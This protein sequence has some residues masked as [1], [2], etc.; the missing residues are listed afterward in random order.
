MRLQVAERDERAGRS[1]AGTGV[2]PMAAG[3]R[4]RRP[5]AT[6]ARHARA[7]GGR[8]RCGAVAV[9]SGDGLRGDVP[10]ARRAHD[11]R[12]PDAQPLDLRPARRH[13][14]GAGRGGR[15]A[16]EQRERDHGRRARRASSR[17]SRCSWRPTTSQQA[18][19]AAAVALAPD[20]LGRG[21]RARPQRG[22]R[23]RAHRRRRA[24]R[25][26][27]RPGALQA[28]RGGRL[29]RGR[30]ARLG[31]PARDAARGPRARSRAGA[32]GGSARADQ[33]ARRRGR[34]A[35]R[36][37]RSRGW[38][39]ATSSSSCATAASRP[40]G[41][42]WPPSSAPAPADRRGY[43]RRRDHDDAANAR[44][45]THAPVAARTR[46]TP[47]RSPSRR[48]ARVR[49]RRR[50]SAASEL[51]AAPVRWPRPVAPGG[52]AERCSRQADG[53]GHRRARAAT[54]SATCSSTCRATAARRA[55]SPR[56][57]RASRPPSRCRCARSPRAPVRRRGHA[58]A[59]RGDA[60]L[61]A[62]GT[63]ARRSSTSRGSSS[64]TR[65]ARGCCCT[66]RPT[67]AGG[68]RVSHHARPTAAP[69]ARRGGRA[70]AAIGRALP[71]R[72]GVSSTQILTLVQRRAAARSRDVAETLPAAHARG[73]APARPRRAR[74]RRCTS[75]ASPRDPR[76]GARRLAFEELLLTQLAVPAPP[77]AQRRARTG[78]RALAERAVAERALARAAGCRSRP[79]PTSA[80]RS[81]RSAT[82][83]RSRAPMQ[84]LLMGEVGSGKTVVALY[85]ML[86]AVEHGHQAALMAPT[87][88][89]AEQHF[90]TLQRLL[91]AEPVRVAL[92]TGSTPARRRAGHPRQA[93]ERRAVAD[94]RHARADRARR[95]ASAR[96]RWPWSTSS[97]A[98]ACASARRSRA[99]AGAPPHMLHM[100]ATPIPRTLAL[101]RY[102]DLDT[103][104]LRELPPGASRSRRAWSA[105]Q[106]AGASAYEQLREQLRARAPGVR[107]VPADRGG[108]E[109]AGAAS[110]PAGPAEQR[111]ARGDGRARAP[112]RGRAA[113]ATSSRCC[114]AACARA[115]SRRRWPR[116][117]PARP[118]CSSRRP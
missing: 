13:P 39:T 67:A 62:T 20:A 94:R 70:P 34:A 31:R 112:A 46:P 82:I 86:R 85:A 74:S 49:I 48:S 110:Q 103:S 60:C 8:V 63:C 19:L 42:C 118:T 109:A 9:V 29:R 91:G 107:R 58:P 32:D 105:R 89:L 104:T 80:R 22:A 55:R 61:D 93:R 50:P 45:E 15:R 44:D 2:G 54:P 88:T 5:S 98:S 78:A 69:S 18:G 99:P 24:G 72:E 41:G 53:R 43:D 76:P 56:C 38:S 4:P 106:R 66:A 115:R 84:R 65:P 52:P 117:P 25:A 27:R 16:A 6:P 36:S 26:R 81:T 95:R 59:G 64:A 75:R 83:S 21:E 23:A 17:T 57:A 77:R 71:G 73:R 111:P 12:R 68:F 1:R 33:R 116:S 79:P 35:R 90:A 7:A 30:G 108:R 37:A 11:R 14:R 10:R 101:A 92:L 47:R 51:L 40:T 3:K 100:T 97:T 96:W 102:G 113:R 87:E 114:T 28:R